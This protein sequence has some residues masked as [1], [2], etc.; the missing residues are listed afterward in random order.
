MG[1]REG[2][3]GGRVGRGGEGRVC[4]VQATS[5]ATYIEHCLSPMQ[6]FGLK[7]VGGFLLHSGCSRH[8]MVFDT[9][10]AVLSASRH[11]DTYMLP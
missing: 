10:K 7:F 11:S 8:S 3:E 6:D 2:G 9:A 4:L 5:S 1:G